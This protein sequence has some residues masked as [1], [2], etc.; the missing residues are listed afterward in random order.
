MAEIYIPPF[1]ILSREY[2]SHFKLDFTYNIKNDFSILL[3]IIRAHDI[4]AYLVLKKVFDSETEIL[5]VERRRKYRRTKQKIWEAHLE[6]A[7]LEHG[8][9]VFACVEFF[10]LKNIPLGKLIM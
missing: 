7:L 3:E 5:L 2:I 9:N 8:Q 10:K 1:Y 4:N 6:I